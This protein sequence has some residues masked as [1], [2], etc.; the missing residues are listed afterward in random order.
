MQAFQK[1][2]PIAKDVSKAILQLSENGVL[3]SLSDKWFTEPSECPSAHKETGRLSVEG[4]RVL[5]PISAATSTVCFLFYFFQR[6]IYRSAVI[7][8]DIP[9]DPKVEADSR[10]EVPDT[11]EDIMVET[12][13]VEAHIAVPITLL[14]IAERRALSCPTEI[15]F[16]STGGRSSHRI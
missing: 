8:P 1:G 15:E 13:K 7:V 3:T 12:N 10:D 4:F 9:E 6:C 14:S 5:Y 11:P 2:S 16:S